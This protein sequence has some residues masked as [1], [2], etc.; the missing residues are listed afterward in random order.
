MFKRIGVLGHPLRPLSSEISDRVM[1]DLKKRAIDSWARSSWDEQEVGA[2][3][4]DSDLVIAIGGDGSMLRAARVSAR[5]GVPVF[6]IN[7]GHLGFLTETNAEDWENA[8]EMLLEGRYW[9]EE[10]MMIRAEAWRA[11]ERLSF[12]DALNDIVIS[13]GS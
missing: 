3:I 13:R 12:D 8:L 5:A 10:R 1:Q 9:I 4:T 6:G 2:E 11:K 7:A